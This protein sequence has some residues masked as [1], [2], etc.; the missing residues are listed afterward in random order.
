MSLNAVFIGLVVEDYS[1]EAKIVTQTLVLT[2]QINTI[3]TGEF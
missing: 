2:T 3:I 1:Q